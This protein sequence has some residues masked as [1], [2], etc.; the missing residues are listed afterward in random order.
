ISPVPP[1]EKGQ[2]PFKLNVQ[3]PEEAVAS[4]EA[5]AEVEAQREADGGAAT[6][7]IH[8]GSTPSTGQGGSA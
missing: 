1:R 5:Q 8:S 2:G 7:T 4:V 6:I 3:T